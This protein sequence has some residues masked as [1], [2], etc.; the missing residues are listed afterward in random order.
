MLFI[1]TRDGEP[2]VFIADADGGN[3]H[4]LTKIAAGVQ[5][6]LVVSPDGQSMAFVS[7][8]YAGCG[9]EA[10]NKA[11]AEEERTEPAHGAEQ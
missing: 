11:R 9:D 5:E 3:V 2:Q 4:K 6:P 10:C 8:V 1:S 7:D